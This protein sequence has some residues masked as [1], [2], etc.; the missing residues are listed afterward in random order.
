MH[1]YWFLD[2]IILIS[3]LWLNHGFFLPRSLEQK[4]L[5]ASSP[6]RQLA[7]PSP[8]IE[9]KFQPINY[10]DVCRFLSIYIYLIDYYIMI[11]AKI[12]VL[13]RILVLKLRMKLELLC[14][15]LY[16]VYFEA[17]MGW[18]CIYITWRCSGETYARL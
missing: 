12:S 6:N 9:M 7:F 11:N 5:P 13:K 16:I 8:L 17:V 2:S 14:K 3:E 18:K 15:F 10:L 1:S 4:G